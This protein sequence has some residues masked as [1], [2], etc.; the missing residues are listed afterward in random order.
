MTGRRSLVPLAVLA[1]LTG[2]AGGR[3]YLRSRTALPVPEGVTTADGGIGGDEPRG[4]AA[5]GH[6]SLLAAAACIGLA[7]LAGGGLL[8]WEAVRKRQETLAVATALTH[9]DPRRAPALMA[10]FGCA[11]C[12]TIPGIP[13][14]DGKVAPSLEGLRTRVFVGGVLR[15][16]G[17]NLVTW[18]VDPQS[19]SPRSAMPA[20]G[21]SEAEARDVAAWLYAH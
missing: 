2:F 5:A 4:T 12:H 9:G 17:E 3:L 7:L 8:G 11:G 14:A 1:A 18:I 13:G 19:V 15:N 21:I 10:R 16:S 6:A 20:T